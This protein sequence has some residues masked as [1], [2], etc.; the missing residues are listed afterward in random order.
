MLPSPQLS[1]SEERRAQTATSAFSPAANL[2]EGEQAA[3]EEE[4]AVL[5]NADRIGEVLTTLRNALDADETGVLTLLKNSEN[6]LTRIREHFPAAGN[7]P[8]ACTP[9]S[10]S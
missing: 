6:D 1:A 9:Y 10:R 2:R 5:E 7:T 8:H 4:L 3:I